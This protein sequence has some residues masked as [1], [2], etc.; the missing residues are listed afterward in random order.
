MGDDRDK[1]VLNL[2]CQVVF[3]G[4]LSRAVW[5]F[6]DMSIQIQIHTRALLLTCLNTA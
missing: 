6:H 3:P 1:F 5:T 2:T 4:L